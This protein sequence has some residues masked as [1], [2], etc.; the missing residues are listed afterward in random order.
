MKNK[1]SLIA[2]GLICI[3]LI[4]YRTW[5]ITPEKPLNVTRWDAFGYYMYLPAILIYHDYKKLDWLNE[6]DKKYQ[7]TGGDGW[8]AQKTDNG[9]YAFKYLGGIAIMQLPAFFIGDFIAKH[10]H[11]PRDGFSAPYQYALSFCVLFYCFLAI[12]LLIKILRLYFDDTTTAIT[13]LLLCLATNF[14]EYAAYGNGLSHAYL[15]VLYVSVLYTTIKW[16]RQPKIIWAILTGYIIG[17]ATI[18][19]PTE[20]IMFLIPLL[21][22]THAKEIA[23]EKWQQVSEHKFH[24]VLAILFGL[25]GIAPQLIYWKLATG[26]FIYDVGS[27]W[28]FLNPHFRVLFGW[29]KGWF[30]Y[31]PVTVLFIIGMFFIKKYPFKNS[32]IWFCLLNIWIIT[33]WSVWRYGGSYSTRALVQSYPVF[34]L[35]F[36][37]IIEKI[38]TSKWRYPFY[39]LAFY[40]L[41]VNIFQTY[42]Y[43]KTILHYDDMNRL[44]YGRIYLNPNPSPLD[45]S[46][47]DDEEVLNN[48]KDYKKTLL[49]DNTQSQKLQFTANNNYPIF[50]DTITN[51]DY[52]WI[53]VE[54]TIFAPGHL[55]KTYLNAS[56]QTKDSVKQNRVRLFSPISDEKQANNYAFFMKVPN[57][58]NKGAITIFLR[59]ESDFVGTIQNVRITLFSYK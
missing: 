5:S 21:W 34:A 41:V 4:Q 18:S 38:K 17:L 44:Y 45:M 37:A 22:N 40:L 30:I 10:S 3:V 20:A 52:K 28:D 29:E 36:A 13:I 33:A 59:S 35:P 48:E 16:H 47:L 7:A 19:R 6:I 23:K 11:F 49:I 39:V 46:L 27:K 2:F 25:I 32:V 14:I 15:F 58:F 42:Q 9:N 26:S 8:Q 57:D 53:K 54:A 24:I 1:I 12:L 51:Q 43:N 31:T 55:W 56:L 50:S